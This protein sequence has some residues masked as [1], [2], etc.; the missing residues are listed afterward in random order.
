MYFNNCRDKK[1]NDDSEKIVKVNTH[2]NRNI[3]FVTVCGILDFF[4]FEFK[5]KL[6]KLGLSFHKQ[7]FLYSQFTTFSFRSYN[8]YSKKPTVSRIHRKTFSRLQS[9]FTNSSWIHLIIKLIQYKIGKTHLFLLF[10][11]SKCWSPSWQYLW[12]VVIQYCY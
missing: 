9:C 10:R 8:F 11:L 4:Y 12:C 5:I 3:N 2:A 6:S 7:Q 1:S